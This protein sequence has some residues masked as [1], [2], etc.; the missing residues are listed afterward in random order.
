[1]CFVSG[2]GGRETDTRFL[3]TGVMRHGL[4]RFDIPSVTSDGSAELRFAFSDD[5]TRL[6]TWD[7]GCFR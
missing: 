7:S 2:A 6:L 5:G 4:L 3:K 1:M